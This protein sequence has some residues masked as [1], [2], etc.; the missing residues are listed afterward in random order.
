MCEVTLIGQ[1]VN[2]YRFEGCDFGRLLRELAAMD[3]D[4]EADIVESI[5]PLRRELAR[6]GRA[7]FKFVVE[8]VEQLTPNMVRVVVGGDTGLDGHAQRRGRRDHE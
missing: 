2:A 1:T 3:G 4:M 6:R 8:T 5:R 7:R